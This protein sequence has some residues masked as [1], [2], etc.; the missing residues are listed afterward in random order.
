MSHRATRD[1]RGELPEEDD[2]TRLGPDVRVGLCG[3]LDPMLGLDAMQRGRARWLELRVMREDECVH[4]AVSGEIYCLSMRV[5]GHAGG[6]ISVPPGPRSGGSERES[7]TV[8][9]V[10]QLGSC[11]LLALFGR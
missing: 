4:S 8:G 2:G 11:A 1:E 9:Q 6:Y 10:A 3:G 7:R 5:G